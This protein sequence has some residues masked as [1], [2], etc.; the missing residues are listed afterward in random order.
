MEALR[1]RRGVKRLRV[2]KMA[3]IRNGYE[4]RMPLHIYFEHNNTIEKGSFRDVTY[5]RPVGT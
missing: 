3:N 5:R 4:K 2:E 1:S